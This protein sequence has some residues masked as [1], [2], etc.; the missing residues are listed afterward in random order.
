MSLKLCPRCRKPPPPGEL[1]CPQHQRYA[2]PE[3]ILAKLPEAPLLG[4]ALEGRY[5]LVDWIGAGGMGMVYRGLDLRLQRP[6]AV[7]LLHSS[8]MSVP[9]IRSRFEREALAMSRL[10]SPHTVTLFD[11]G[12]ILKGALA[13]VAF[14]I[15]GL[16][17]GESLADRLLRQGSLKAQEVMQILDQLADSLF[18]AH[19]QGI[20]HR[21]VKPDNILLEQGYENRVQVK[22]IDFGVARVEGARS[23]ISGSYLGTP[24]YMSPEQ[25]GSGEAVDGRAD[26]YALALVAYE[27]LCGQRAFESAQNPMEVI[28]AQVHDPPAP[29]PHQEWYPELRALEPVLFQALSKRVKDRF[30]NIRAFSRAFQQALLGPEERALTAASL[31]DTQSFS[32]LDRQ[33]LQMALEKQAQTKPEILIPEQGSQLKVT[34]L[35][36]PAEPKPRRRIWWLLSSL[37]LVFFLLSLKFTLGGLYDSDRSFPPEAGL[38]SPVRHQLYT[39]EDQEL[40]PQDMGLSLDSSE[41]SPDI[42]SSRSRAEKGRNPERV[43]KRVLKGKLRASSPSSTLVKR[44]Q[45]QLEQALKQCLCSK[46]QRLWGNLKLKLHSSK[47]RNKLE[48][49][50]KACIEGDVDDRCVNGILNPN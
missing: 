19:T 47:I 21:D 12:L 46:A 8:L 18:E 5:A 22:L 15:L 42:K 1:L 25:C 50:V 24:E 7:K 33:Q 27:C 23:T 30:E 3:A 37:L 45:E 20:T 2:L 36:S 44:L 35:L 32:E 41:L 49:R 10:K 34:T 26:Q 40:L 17:E 38:L 39:V 28:Y 11:Y 6:V 29:M 43:K 31:S 4:R 9:E 14:M 13:N 16:V 48:R